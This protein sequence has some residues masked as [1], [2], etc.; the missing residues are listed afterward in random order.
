MLV[1]VHLTLRQRRYNFDRHQKERKDMADQIKP[2]E[3]RWENEMKEGEVTY[4]TLG[5][6]AAG[7]KQWR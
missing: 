5:R 7:R 3:G 6:K 4:N 1:E 2:G